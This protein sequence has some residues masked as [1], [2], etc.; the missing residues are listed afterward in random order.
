MMKD[1]KVQKDI[2]TSNSLSEGEGRGEAPLYIIKI[3]GNVIDNPTQLD[4]FLKDFSALQGAKILIHGGGK[5]ATQTAA[6]LGV[7]TQMVNGRR[8]TDAA[9]LDVVT[10]VYAGLVNK[11][12]V[13]KLQALGVD[14]VGMTGAD[15]NAI[16]AIK[17]PVKD[18]DFGYVGDLMPDSVNTQTINKLLVND[19]V[20]VFSAL[21]HDG[22]GQLFNTNADTIASA[23]AVSLSSIYETKLVYCFEKNGVMRDIN[24]ANSIISEINKASFN[25]LKADGIIADGMLP[26]LQNAFDAISNGVKEVYIGHAEK[27]SNL[28][29]GRIFGTRLKS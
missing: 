29:N 20:P 18:V 16:K 15:A 17:R 24:D 13:A 9:M 2:S 28:Q 27:L 12:I 21:T 23:L 8:I 3:G 26:K 11:N 22:E 4:T 5:I 19:F 6:K 7:E 1:L 25:Q 10:M 14:A